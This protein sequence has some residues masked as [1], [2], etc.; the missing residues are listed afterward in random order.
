MITAK[1]FFKSVDLETVAR[2]RK[3][4]T[5]SCISGVQSPGL[6]KEDSVNTVFLENILLIEGKYI[7][8]WYLI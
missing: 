3:K 4:K 5:F 6:E 1:Q 8:S 2:K 7:F